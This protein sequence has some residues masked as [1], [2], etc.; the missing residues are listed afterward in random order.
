MAEIEQDTQETVIPSG[1][2]DFGVEY[3]DGARALLRLGSEVRLVD[4]ADI[5]NVSK[6]LA[7]AFQYTY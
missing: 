5:F 4:Q 1:V 6:Q 2:A 3:V 7:K